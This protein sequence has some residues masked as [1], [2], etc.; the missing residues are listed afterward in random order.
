MRFI[1]TLKYR[2]ISTIILVGDVHLWGKQKRVT[3]MMEEYIY[4][5][6]P[7]LHS[8]YNRK[9][10]V[11][12]R[13]LTS[14]E[15]VPM[16]LDMMEHAGIFPP[17]C[18]H[19]ICT[20]KWHGSIMSFLL[21]YHLHKMVCDYRAVPMVTIVPSSQRLSRFALVKRIVQQLDVRLDPNGTTPWYRWK[22]GQRQQYLHRQT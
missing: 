4:Q 20:E 9:I 21:Q 6:F 7:E 5:N 16:G 18:E 2:Q 10:M 15:N 14:R 1:S 3:E 8:H 12:S 17:D 19:V 11:E 22:L 13:S